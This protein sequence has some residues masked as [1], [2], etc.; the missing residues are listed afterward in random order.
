VGLMIGD[1]TS[2]GKGIAFEAIELVTQYGFEELNLRKLTA[3]MYEQNVGSYKS[4]LKAG[5]QE[6]G[7]YKQHFF[8][9]GHF[10]DG[11]LLE[12]CRPQDYN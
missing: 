9:Q 12:R 6:V 4:F 10:I 2:W 11:I 7:R 1:K 3:G 8:L 5:Y